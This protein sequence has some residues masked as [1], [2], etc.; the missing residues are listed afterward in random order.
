[1]RG[2]SSRILLLV[3]LLAALA[4]AGGG[5]ERVCL[6]P[7]GPPDPMTWPDESSRR[8]SAD[9][10]RRRDRDPKD[11]ATSDPPRG[12]RRNEKLTAPGA[13]AKPTGR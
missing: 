1:M 10:T 3:A 11:Q 12:P 8:V 4:L 6:S 9:L 5:R 7:Q 13:D 2:F